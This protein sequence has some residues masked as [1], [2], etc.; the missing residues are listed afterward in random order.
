M[1]AIVSLPNSVELVGGT[2]TLYK[3]NLLDGA[4]YNE[5]RIA[6][7]GVNIGDYEEGE[8]ANIV[9]TVRIKS[10][11]EEGDNKSDYMG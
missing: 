5:D 7:K 6:T 2:T 11:L 8:Q 9:C 4:V 3:K 10:G 1:V